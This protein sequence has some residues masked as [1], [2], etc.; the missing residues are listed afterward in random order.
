MRVSIF[1]LLLFII[2]SCEEVVVVNLPDSQ[3]LVVVEGGVS[4][5]VSQQYVRVTR[6]NGFSDQNPII[7][8]EDADVIVQ[9]ETGDVFFYSYDS[10]GYYR[11]N[12]Q[13]SGIL[14]IRYRVRILL[15]NGKEIRSEWERMRDAVPINSLTV[16]SFLQNDPENPGDQILIYFPKIRVI[17]PQGVQNYYRFIFFK[18]GQLYT[19]PEFITIIDD[20]FFDGNLV[21]NNFESFA[22]QRED[23]L[24]IQFQSISSEMFKY[25][26]LLKSQIT[27]LGT[28]SGTTPIVINGNLKYNSPEQTEIVLGYFGTVA[29]SAD[30]I[31]VQ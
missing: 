13:F 30:T 29:A 16:E 9:N 3:R 17:D 19:E 2:I 12:M 5:V 23:E 15:N 6:S 20:H 28:S 14:G 7:P 31:I 4:E 10:D 22:Y 26:R 21:P 25:L 24:I 8:V 27:T 11:S 18:N 1:I